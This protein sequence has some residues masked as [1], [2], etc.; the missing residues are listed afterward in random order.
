MQHIESGFIDGIHNAQQ[1]FRYILKALSEPGTVVTLNKHPGFSP[2]NAAASQ[3]IMSLCDQQTG[4]Y[5]SSALAESR[6]GLEQAWHNLAFHN[7]VSSTP[8]EEADYLVVSG[9]EDLNLQRVKA[10]TDASPE[11]SASVLVQTTGFDKGPRFR[12]SGPGIKHS[13]ELQ[14]GELSDS[15]VNYLLKPSHRYP[16]GIDF[17]FCHQQSLVAISR[18]T[19]LELISCM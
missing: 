17:M 11:L 1:C 9:I 10:G 4:V 5:L 2:L 16:L 7:G 14:L 3:I 15:L 12:L 6:D 8:M 18:T 19:K 13:V